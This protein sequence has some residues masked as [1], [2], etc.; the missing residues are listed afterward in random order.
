MTTQVNTQ[1]G[2]SKNPNPSESSSPVTW[3]LTPEA[4][5]YIINVLGDLPSKTGVYPLVQDLV[6]QSQ[7]VK[8]GE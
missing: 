8:Q 4:A 7:P 3:V 5:Q 6:K 2:Q 1:Q